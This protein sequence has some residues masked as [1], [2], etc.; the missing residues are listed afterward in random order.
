MGQIT[1]WCSPRFFLRSNILQHLN[2][3]FFKS[4]FQEYNQGNYTD[5]KSFIVFKPTKN[6]FNLLDVDDEL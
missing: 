6:I 5:D 4:F 3:L 2:K 1:S